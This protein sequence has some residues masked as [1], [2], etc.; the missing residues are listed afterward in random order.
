MISPGSSATNPRRAAG[1]LP[2]GQAVEIRACWNEI[3]VQGNGSCPELRKVIHCRNCPVYSKAGVQLLDRPLLPRIPPGMDRAFRA[4]KK[5]R[6]SSQNLRPALPHQRGMARAAH[7]RFSGSGRAPAG[8][9]AAASAARH[10]AGPRQYSWR[11]ADL[12]LPRPLAGTGREPAARNGPHQVTIGCWWQ[13]GTAIGSCSRRMR[14]TAS[15][16][17]KR[18][19]CRNRRPRWRNPS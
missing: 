3:G 19:N 7:A 16:G 2:N 17:F 10:C 6:G 8:S 13:D 5:A 4:G 12:C 9:F 11:T 18:W 14:S 15:I 1:P